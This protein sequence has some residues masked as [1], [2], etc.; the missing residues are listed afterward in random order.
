MVCLAIRCVA[1]SKS[2]SLSDVASPT[3]RGDEIKLDPTPSHSS[4]LLAPK[5]RLGRLGFASHFRL[6]LWRTRAWPPWHT[7]ETQPLGSTG[8]VGRAPLHELQFLPHSQDAASYSMAAGVT[9]H[10]WGIGDIVL[11]DWE[12][13]DE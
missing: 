1:Q 7:A 8:I 9:D 11:G 2:P 12:V 4:T 5:C 6:W 10:L 3:S 13:A